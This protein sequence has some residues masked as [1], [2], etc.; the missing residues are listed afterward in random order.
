MS[1]RTNC[2]TRSIRVVW[3]YCKRNHSNQHDEG[4]KNKEG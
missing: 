3:H 4:N 2:E 1:F